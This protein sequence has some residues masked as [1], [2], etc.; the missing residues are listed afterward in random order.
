[1]AR[2]PFCEILI[3]HDFCDDAGS[4]ATKALLKFISMNTLIIR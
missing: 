4:Y 1:M 3:S 2:F